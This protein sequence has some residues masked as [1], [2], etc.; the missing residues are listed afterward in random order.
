[1]S[2]RWTKL[3]SLSVRAPVGASL[4]VRCSGRSCVFKKR[5]LKHTLRSPTSVTRYFG[6]K[7]RLA[8]GTGITVRVIRKAAGIY[9]RISIQN[10]RKPKLTRGCVSQKGTLYRCTP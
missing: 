7:R 5:I 2:P 3:V 9:Q 1:V 4:D 10:G 6:S 8:P